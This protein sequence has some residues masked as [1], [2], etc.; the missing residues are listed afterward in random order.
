MTWRSRLIGHTLSMIAI[1]FAFG[2]FVMILPR[3]EAS[4]TSVRLVSSVGEA[5]KA[6]LRLSDMP[7]GWTSSPSS[8]GNS[9]FPGEDQLAHCLGVPASVINGNPPT[10]NSPDFSSKNSLL[11]VSD[12]I[13][14]YPLA[15]SAQAENTS[16]RSPKAPMC[17]ADVINGVAKGQLDAVF[18]SGVKVGRVAV[19]RVPIADLAPQGAN[20]VMSMPVTSQ[21]TTLHL[22]IT[23]F[24]YVKEN[25]EQTVD[26]TSV[27]SSFPPSLMRQLSTL[28]AERL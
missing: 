11:S 23:I 1:G 27:N 22:V 20:I 24:D 14:V 5:G 2:P 9:S 16:L 26:F 6:L 12:S 21:G 17:L 8:N 7:K 18:G 25:Q 10:V 15:K 13:S 3:S 19:A 4:A 28:A